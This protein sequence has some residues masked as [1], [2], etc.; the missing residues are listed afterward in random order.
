MSSSSSSSSSSEEDSIMSS[1]EDAKSPP[2]QAIAAAASAQPNSVKPHKKTSS[3]PTSILTL[4]QK[5]SI[6]DKQWLGKLNLMKACINED[7]SMDYSSLG[8]EEAT[9]RMQNF[10]KDQRKCFRKREMNKTSPMTDDRLRLLSEAKFNFKPSASIKV[11]QG[12]GNG[13]KKK[14]AKPRKE[15]A[16]KETAANG[17]NGTPATTVIDLCAEKADPPTKQ[18]PAKSKEMASGSDGKLSAKK[19]PKSALSKASSLTPRKKSG[20]PTY[21]EMAQ[22]AIFALKERTGS[23]VPAISKWIIAN[24][25]HASAAHPTTFK[26]RVSS[27]IK[28]GV[29]D[30]RF[31][32]VKASYKINSEWTRKQKAA[33]KAQEAAKKK[34]EKEKAKAKQ[35]QKDIDT[36]KAE[37]A[38]AEVDRKKVDDK[39]TLAAIFLSPE[40]RAA[41]AKKTKR[42]EEVEARKKHIEQQLKKRRC[43]IEDTRLH[44]EDREWGVKPPEYVI[45]RPVLPHTLTSIIPPHLRANTPKKYVRPVANASASGNGPLMGGENERG[46]IS[47]AIHVYHFFCGDVGLVDADYPVPKF[48]IKTLFY[49]LDEVLNGNAKT[50]RS[51]PP[52][53]TH[54]FVTA[55]RMLTADVD[56]QEDDEV[57]PVDLRLQEDLSKLREGLN[58]VSWSQICFFYFDLMERF[59]DSDVS[60]E[61]GVLPGEKHLDMSYFWNKDQINE[62]DI[63]TEMKE[64]TDKGYLGDPQGIL[65]KGFFKL[66][67]QNEPWTLKADELMALLRT[68]TDDILAKQPD[69]AEDIAGR[70]AK[71]YELSKGKRAAVVKFNK[72]RLAHEGPKKPIRQ[73]K[74]DV[75]ESRNDD[76]KDE[77]ADADLKEESE[78]PFVPTA[79]KQQFVAAEKAYTKAVDAYETGLNRLIMRTEPIGFDR[80]F[81]AIYFFRHDPD[82]LHVEQLKQSSLP[83][84][85]KLLGAEMT[86]FSSWHVIDT[87]PLFEQFL[88]SLD[89]RGNREDETLSICSNLTIVKRRLLDEKKENTRVVA[90]EREKEELQRRLENAKSACDAKDG[91]RSGRLAGIAQDELMKVEV[92]IGIMAKAHKTEE[93]QEKLGRE[94]ASDYSLLTGLQMV[95]DLFAGQ[96]ATRSSKRSDNDDQD[97]AAL[98]ANVP[99]HKLWVDERIGGN[100]TL[101]VLVESLL[102]LEGKCNDLSPWANQ[103][104]TREI[105]RKKLS[106]A[107]CA[108]AIDCVMQLGPSADAEDADEDGNVLATPAKKQK[109]ELASGSTLANIVN[110]IKL[111]VKDLEKRIFEVSGK[112]RSIEEANT[113]EENEEAT[114][115]DENDEEITKRRNNWK[116]KINALRRVPAHRYAIIRDIIVAAITVA[117]KSHLNQVAAELKTALQL[118]RP[119]AGGEAR[120]A[121]IQVLEK[122]GGYDGYDDEDKDVDFDELAAA[123][124]GDK[125]PDDEAGG[126]EIASLLCDEIR[127]ISGSVGGD[128]FAD[129]SDWSDAIKDCKSVSRLAVVL[130]SLVAKADNVLNQIK[131]ERSNLDRILGLNAKRTSRSKSGIK[132]SH[133]SSTAVWCDT[134]LTDR[135]VKARVNGFPWWPAHVCDPLDSVVAGALEGSGYTLIS[136]VGNPGMFMVAE[137]DIA[138]FTQERDEDLSQYE[139]SVLEELHESTTIAKKLWRLRNRG[140]AS[141]WRKKKSRSKV[142][143]EDEEKKTAY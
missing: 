29:K 134:N 72:V 109:V 74:S 55:L 20:K 28:Q 104:T 141:P 81:N 69:L 142:R 86:P 100:G 99:P 133:D 35:N 78:K 115:D 25:A 140:M 73:K 30:G 123:N 137:K 24:N 116:I 5:V 45:K 101:Q 62:E 124:A 59:Y 67:N 4:T 136:S 143:E 77:E 122:H 47:D 98:L 19:S 126:A 39:K 108:W 128:D 56:E 18:T 129:A 50:A 117:R 120:A 114:S 2:K 138:E 68:L 65:A 53:L 60:L 130:Q 111:C 3:I 46:L 58:A 139:Q 87:K 93:Q 96:R 44:R 84:E 121:A 23:S 10:V 12:K 127:M 112:K 52:L 31:V 119:Q 70:G 11:K 92:E 41:A 16:K 85:I 63:D 38:K 7:G 82:M 13:E 107:S 105:W 14:K 88:M 42:K 118:L 113:V 79:S 135:L 17:E 95:T 37:A 91:K 83:P 43:P 22:D 9:K 97:E 110:T 6:Y 51:L 40:E 26:N 36:A 131:E 89:K 49:S 34:A 8:D 64:G 57:E 33:A 80:N 102:T 54:L 71:L 75:N 94:K 76:K 125:N 103:S 21:V 61:E 90:R 27:S 1:E 15:T 66:Q 48:S 132:K 106:E 32:K